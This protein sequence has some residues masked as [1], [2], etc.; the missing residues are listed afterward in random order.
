MIKGGFLL[1]FLQSVG[2]VVLDGVDNVVFN[3]NLQNGFTQGVGER[4]VGTGVVRA[5][6][7]GHF[8]GGV[9]NAQ[10]FRGAY[11]IVGKHDSQHMVNGIVVRVCIDPKALAHIDLIQTDV[12]AA[13][14]FV[15]GVVNVKGAKGGN[16]GRHQ[17]VGG[18]LYVVVDERIA[19]AVSVVT[20]RTVVAA[21]DHVT[22]ITFTAAGGD[23][24]HHQRQKRYKAAEHPILFLHNI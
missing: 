7:L 10:T 17:V 18:D 21:D 24:T 5:V 12:C 2:I 9:A 16:Q 23:K 1:A 4:A 11:G 6:Q 19:L 15:V 14:A 22:A 13:G 8:L 20:V 3:D